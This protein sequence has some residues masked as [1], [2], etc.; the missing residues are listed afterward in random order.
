MALFMKTGRCINAWNTMACTFLILGRPN[1]DIHLGH[2]VQLSKGG[3]ALGPGHRGLS[4][5]LSVGPK[6]APS[7]A[8]QHRRAILRAGYP[9]GRGD[10]P[11]QQRM[12][13]CLSVGPSEAS[14]KVEIEAGTQWKHYGTKLNHLSFNFNNSI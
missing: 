11:S 8:P 14:K 3:D 1:S 7:M 4:L 12:S 9:R 13:I 5:C 6:W 2:F 10:T